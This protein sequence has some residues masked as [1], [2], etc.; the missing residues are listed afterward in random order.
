MTET[1]V[2]LVQSVAFPI[3][4]CV[5]MAFYI[6]NKDDKQSESICKL[7]DAINNNTV[8]MQSLIAKIDGLK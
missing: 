5:L 7:S 6:K 8:V 2:S 4:M 3:A 1:I